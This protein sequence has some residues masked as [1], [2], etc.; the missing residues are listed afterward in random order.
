MI[1]ASS[2]DSVMSPTHSL[3]NSSVREDYIDIVFSFL[4]FFILLM[5]AFYFVYRRRGKKARHCNLKNIQ[6]TVTSKTLCDHLLV[7]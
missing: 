7:F 3:S 4:P 6:D 5:R 1:E 2:C